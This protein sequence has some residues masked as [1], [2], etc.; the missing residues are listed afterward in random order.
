[1]QLL[2]HCGAA[3]P[4]LDVQLAEVL[5]HKGNSNVLGVQAEGV[6][7]PGDLH[8]WQ[9]SADGLLLNLKHINLDMPY[10]VEPSQLRHFNGRAGGRCIIESLN[11]PSRY[12]LLFCL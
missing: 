8:D 10:F 12:H 7:K 2:R 6:P 3:L 5:L 9:H 11:C 4:K 1:M